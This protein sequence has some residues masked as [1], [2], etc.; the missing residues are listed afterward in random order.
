MITATSRRRALDTFRK[1][2]GDSTSTNREKGR[3][4]LVNYC[5][6]VQN[7]QDMEREPPEGKWHSIPVT[8]LFPLKKEQTGRM[9]PPPEEKEGGARY[10]YVALF[11]FTEPKRAHHGLIAAQNRKRERPEP[12]KGRLKLTDIC[13]NGQGRDTYFQEKGRLIP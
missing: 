13:H 6:F 12:H 5:F 8:G 2:C 7:G 4:M 1:A 3:L 11:L 9:R 10:S